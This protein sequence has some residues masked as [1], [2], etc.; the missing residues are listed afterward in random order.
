MIHRIYRYG[1]RV[2]FLKEIKFDGQ[3][4]YPVWTRDKE[5]AKVYH[6]TRAA[7]ADILRIDGVREMGVTSEGR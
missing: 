2:W 5:K 7:F 4:A 1:G 3:L 6:D